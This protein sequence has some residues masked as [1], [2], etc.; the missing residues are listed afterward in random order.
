MQHIVEPCLVWLKQN[1]PNVESCALFGCPH[2]GR[3]K[4][5]YAGMRR[6]ASMVMDAACDADAR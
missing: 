6:L 2:F 5:W 3:M 4:D 1:L